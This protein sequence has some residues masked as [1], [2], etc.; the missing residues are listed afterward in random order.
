MDCPSPPVSYASSLEPH[1][2]SG[3]PHHITAERLEA[4]SARHPSHSSVRRPD[5]QPLT[6]PPPLPP[7]PVCPSGLLHSLVAMIKGAWVFKR[8]KNLGIRKFSFALFV[9]FLLP[10]V[11]C[12]RVSGLV[13][14]C[15][16][17]PIDDD[18]DD[19]EKN[20]DHVCSLCCRGVARNSG[21]S[22]RMISLWVPLHPQHPPTPEPQ[23]PLFFFFLF[24]FWQI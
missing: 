14:R 10:K 23:M 15:V 18:D 20:D 7:P 6:L 16:W 12:M 4:E 21:P 22:E 24:F 8:K 5:P 11:V 2:V 3:L 19:D 1:C 17:V 9:Y 13:C